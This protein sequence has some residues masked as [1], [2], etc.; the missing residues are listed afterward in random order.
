MTFALILIS[1]FFKITEIKY[2]NNYVLSQEV[3]TKLD[4]NKNNPRISL[5]KYYKIY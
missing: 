2:S 1:T 5:Y 4:K 3:S